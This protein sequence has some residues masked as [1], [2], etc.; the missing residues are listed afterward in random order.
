MVLF[1]PYLPALSKLQVAFV[2]AYR[3]RGRC[4]PEVD[5]PVRKRDLRDIENEELRRR[6][7]QLQQE[8]ARL[9]PLRHDPSHQG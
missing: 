7:Q 5:R 4:G 8:L 6:V 1:R 3:G 2:M 9:Q